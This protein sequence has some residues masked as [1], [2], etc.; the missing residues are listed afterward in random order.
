M[1]EYYGLIKDAKGIRIED[2]SGLEITLE[3]YR[4]MGA[5]I[6]QLI[7]DRQPPPVTDEEA[8]VILAKP[9]ATEEDVEALRRWIEADPERITSKKFA[10]W[11]QRNAVFLVSR[12]NKRLREGSGS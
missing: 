3:E 6:A 10:A 9:A 7:K 8:E 5:H 4:I 2:E 11:S 1:S 12:I